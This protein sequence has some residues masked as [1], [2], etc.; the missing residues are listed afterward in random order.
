MRLRR[1]WTNLGTFIALHSDGVVTDACDRPFGRDR[2][3]QKF[4]QPISQRARAHAE[5]AE[6]GGVA[7]EDLAEAFDHS[8]K[9]LLG[10]VAWPHPGFDLRQV[11]VML[12]ASLCQRDGLSGL[13]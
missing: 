13:R 7:I 4:I 6:F 3:P 5:V 2:G 10:K 1:K 8:Q 9:T 12:S 11:Y